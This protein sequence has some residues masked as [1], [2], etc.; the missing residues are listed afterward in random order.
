MFG[1][2]LGK[3]RR[4]FFLLLLPVTVNGQLAEWNYPP[5]AALAGNF[6][7]NM[8]FQLGSTQTLSWTS[9]YPTANVSWLHNDA[10]GSDVSAP[11]VHSKALIY[12]FEIRTDRLYRL[13]RQPVQLDCVD[14]RQ[15]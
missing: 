15:H 5:I 11:I 8:L 3:R 9:P 12:S 7:G 4:H 10:D 14:P 6:T 2:S 13:C 1:H